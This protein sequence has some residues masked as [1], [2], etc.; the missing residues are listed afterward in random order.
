MEM[1]CFDKNKLRLMSKCQFYL[2]DRL[3]LGVILTLLTEMLVEVVIQQK[4]GLVLKRK[5]ERSQKN[6]KKAPKKF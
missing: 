4:S 1:V 2:G 3:I 6:I 5:G